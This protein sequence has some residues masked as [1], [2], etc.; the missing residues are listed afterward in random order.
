MLL[1]ETDRKLVWFELDLFWAVF[2]GVDPVDWLDDHQK[3]I[4]LFH[5]KDGVPNPAGGF[6]DPGFTDL[7]EGVIDFRR[8]FKSLKNKNAH[9]YIVERDTQPHPLL[10][11]EKGYEYLRGLRAKG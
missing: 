9:D 10:T 7:G 6:F 11:A 8:I 1:D 5:V 3:R 4:P 2:G